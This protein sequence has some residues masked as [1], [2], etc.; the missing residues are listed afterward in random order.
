M[1]LRL[2]YQKIVDEAVISEHSRT[3]VALRCQ[4]LC[5]R[6]RSGIETTDKPKMIQCPNCHGSGWIETGSGMLPCDRCDDSGKLYPDEIEL[7]K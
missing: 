2:E 6:S 5:D 7:P 4:A 3:I 1:K